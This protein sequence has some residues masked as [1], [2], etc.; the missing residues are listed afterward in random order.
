MVPHHVRHHHRPL[1][2]W[3]TRLDVTLLAAEVFCREV[4]FSGLGRVASDSAD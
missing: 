3:M 1:G 2:L 4:R